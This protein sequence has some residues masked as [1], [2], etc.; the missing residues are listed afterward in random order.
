MTN[1]GRNASVPVLVGLLAALGQTPAAMA[2]DSSDDKA[3]QTAIAAV[4]EM[5][6]QLRELKSFGI[7]ADV[8]YDDVVGDGVLVQRN[9]E[10]TIS[11]RLPDGLRAEIEGADLHRSIT[12]DGKTVTVYGE[13]LGYYAQFEA[14]AT[15]RETLQKAAEKHDL[16]FPL[17]DLFFW[18]TDEDNLADVTAATMVGPANIGGRLCDQYVF[19]QDDVSWQIWITQG[20]KKLPCKLSIVD[21][22]QPARPQY[23]AV[24]D[25]TPEATFDASVF[26]FAPPEGAEKIRIYSAE[27]ADQ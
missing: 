2:A 20:D 14:P 23:S 1:T 12:Y 3:T 15:I 18:G 24:I 9:E 21:L 19:A 10:L 16:Q 4:S 25:M 7:H 26:S 13:T 27:T 5:G 22:T 8:A 11:A 6:K 17:A